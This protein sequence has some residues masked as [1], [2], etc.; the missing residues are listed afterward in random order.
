MIKIIENLPANVFGY[1][2]HGELEARDYD[3]LRPRL[4][5]YGSYLRG[6][7]NLLIEATEATGLSTLALWEE[8]KLAWQDIGRVQRIALVGLPLWTQPFTKIAEIL[9]LAAAIKTY[10]PEKRREAIAWLAGVVS[11]PT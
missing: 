9:H 7:S 4:A 3:L 5:E 8:A 6:G 10:P 1:A 11:Y 2:I